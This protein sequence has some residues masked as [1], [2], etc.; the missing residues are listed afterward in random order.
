[1]G[2]APCTKEADRN[3]GRRRVH[4]Q[5][6]EVPSFP[7]SPRFAIAPPPPP[8]PRKRREEKGQSHDHEQEERD[9]E[10][11]FDVHHIISCISSLRPSHRY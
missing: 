9:G 1:M 11:D 10:L 4:G 3:L 8:S 2:A 6:P 7:V 5:R